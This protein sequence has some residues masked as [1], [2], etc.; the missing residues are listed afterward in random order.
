MKMTRLIP[1]CAAML[2]AA[3]A[4]F[5]ATETVNGV[6]WTYSVSSGGATLGG[7]SSSTPAIPKATSG[8]VEIP[9]EL[10]G[11]PVTT[12]ANYAFS[13]CSAVTALTIPNSVKHSLA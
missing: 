3:N 1:F 8:A 5:A 9:S 11:V 6:E 10:G 2:F 13:G 12:I 4:A 7:G